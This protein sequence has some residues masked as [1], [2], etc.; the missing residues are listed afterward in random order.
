MV[1][2]VLL[3]LV[4]ALFACSPT[5]STPEAPQ[6]PHNEKPKD[7]C[8]IRVGSEARHL[9]DWEQRRWLSKTMRLLRGGKALTHKDPI[10]Q[11]VQT[12]R[13]QVLQDLM[14]SPEFGDFVLD[15]NMY[16]LGFKADRVKSGPTRYVEGVMDLPHAIGSAQETLACGDYEVL[17][18]LNQPF[19]MNPLT[20]PFDIPDGDPGEMPPPPMDPPPT[21][22][23]IRDRLFGRM[24]TSLGEVIK[25]VEDN[26]DLPIVPYC[27]KFQAHLEVTLTSV[28]G[29]GLPFQLIL[30]GPL[31]GWYAPIL[32]ACNPMAPQSIDFLKALN[33]IKQS[34]QSFYE[35]IH[36]YTPDLYSTP[37]VS[38]I[39]TIDL[40]DLGAGPGTQFTTRH[41]MLLVNSS[42]NFNRK[43]A[44]YVLSRFFCDDLT[45]LN[46]EDVDNHSDGHHG[47]DPACYA[48]HHRLDPMAGFFRDYGLQ[49][50]SFAGEDKI[51]FDDGATMDREEYQL[52]WE[53]PPDSGREWNVGFVRSVKDMSK[54][55]YGESLEDLFNIIGS[56]P[57]VKRC[58]V[59]RMFEFVVA[60][61][62][63][64]DPGYLDYLTEEYTKTAVHNT[65][66]AFKETLARLLLGESFMQTDLNPE[67]CYDFPP[68]HNAGAAPPC[69]V[70]HLLQK[71]CVA[72]HNTNNRS[73]G[74]DL[75]KWIATETGERN[76]SHVVSGQ[77][78][79]SVKETFSRFVDRLTTSDENRRMP[80]RK[81]MDP[82]HREALFLWANQV[83]G[84]ANK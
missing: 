54:N 28:F 2:F 49:F 26:P 6:S 60:E 75:T 56:A 73:G 79:L 7:P 43:R 44:A 65:S 81:Y 67:E 1:R 83:L 22:R 3:G 39:R 15:F 71:N 69:R 52:A 36:S 57:E 45:P 18:D 51:T 11:L 24:Q 61:D 16:F 4:S 50:N 58:L 9:S 74:L 27:L 77:G 10:E 68:G 62:Q 78:Q 21:D 20:Q 14:A 38:A 64:L 40:S 37:D 80:S 8:L 33:G 47:S 82:Q 66:L 53:A 41:Q 30:A 84:E 19:Y 63:V 72:C 59:R 48:C 25:F 32:R 46:V 76:F 42:T 34:N 17:L 23:E 5:H 29:L 70:N 31:N 35:R 55:T 12:P 13:Q